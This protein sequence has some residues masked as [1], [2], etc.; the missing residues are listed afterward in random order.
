MKFSDKVKYL[1]TK[2]GL[3]QEELGRLTYL[4]QKTIQ[5]YEKGRITPRMHTAVQLAK[6]LG[7]KPADLMNDERSIA[8]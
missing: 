8:E 3:T 6:V 7:V 5:A 1:R 4:S 2:K